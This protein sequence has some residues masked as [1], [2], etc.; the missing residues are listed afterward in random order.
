MLA[1][2]TSL[3]NF[4]KREDRCFGTGKESGQSEKDD[5]QDQLRNDTRHELGLI[6]AMFLHI[7]EDTFRN[8]FGNGTTGS[9]AFPNLARRYIK[10]HK[11]KRLHVGR[12]ISQ[13]E[14]RPFRHDKVRDGKNG[15]DLL[16]LVKVLAPVASGEKEK[17]V[18][19]GML[20]PKHSKC[21]HGVRNPF[22]P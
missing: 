12:Q 10:W 16:P 3:F 11:V 1:A 9:Q 5:E 22:T 6:K 13:I 4:G 15:L 17:F 14:S 20:F 7:P 19:F 8:P 21:I 2:Q 18:R